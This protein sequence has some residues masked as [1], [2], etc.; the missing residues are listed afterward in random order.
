MLFV[1]ARYD[2]TSC[3][4]TSY[5]PEDQLGDPRTLLYISLRMYFAF[6]G[7]EAVLGEM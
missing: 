1:M 7:A 3:R 6:K 4:A 2:F 5:A